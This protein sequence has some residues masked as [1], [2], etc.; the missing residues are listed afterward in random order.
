MGM[1]GI[2]GLF[3]AH[4]TVSDLDRSIAF[5]RDVLGL[6][7]AHVVPARG[8]AFHWIGA[9]GRAMLGLW[10][11]GSAPLG[12]RL[13]AAFEADLADVLAA[14]VRLRAAGVT[15]LAFG[16]EPTDEPVVLSWMPAAAVYFADP[17]GHSLEVLAMLPHRPRPDLGALPYSTWLT[18]HAVAH[19]A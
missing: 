16:G 7:L 8:V 9:P 17:D 6:P 14:P 13:H 11:I 2:R 19:S 10:S 5:Y 3:E 1:I 15:P 4:L 12:L 18:D